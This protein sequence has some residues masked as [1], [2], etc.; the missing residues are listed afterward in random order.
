MNCIHAIFYGNVQG[1]G[2]RA[3]IRA[4]A[5]SLGLYGWVK[6]LDDGSVESLICGNED[7]IRELMKYAHKIPGAVIDRIVETPEKYDNINE[8]SIIH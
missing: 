5:I 8:F 1:I 3:H 4:K 6:N 2:F 7:K